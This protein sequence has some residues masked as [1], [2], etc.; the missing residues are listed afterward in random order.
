MAAESEENKGIEIPE[1]CEDNAILQTKILM[2]I[3]RFLGISDKD[4]T[5]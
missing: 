2:A 4:I 5:G 3:A 1:N